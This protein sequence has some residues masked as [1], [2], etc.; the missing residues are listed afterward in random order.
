MGSTIYPITGNAYRGVDTQPTIPGGTIASS[1]SLPGY[2]NCFT[3][4]YFLAQGIANFSILI[5]K[6]NKDTHHLTTLN[7][8]GLLMA[9]CD[10]EIDPAN[11]T[12]GDIR[13]GFGA[14]YD[15][16]SNNVILYHQEGN[17]IT[18]SNITMPRVPE[19]GTVKKNT[20]TML[21][22][23]N[24]V[25]L[26]EIRGETGV[27]TLIHTYTNVSNRKLYPVMI[28]HSS[29]YYALTFM[30]KTTFSP[31]EVVS[32]PS[33][34]SDY[35]ARDIQLTNNLPTNMVNYFNYD[36]TKLVAPT[37][38]AGY[39][40]SA[41]RMFV[42][43]LIERNFIL[44]LITFNVESYDSSQKQRRNIISNIISADENDIVSNEPNIIFIDLNNKNKID[45]RNL[46]MRL[47]DEY[48]NPIN[49]SG[50][51][52]AVLLIAGKEERNF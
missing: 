24:K 4:K 5:R 31:Y 46:T 12:A 50:T 9:L 32:T 18:N 20:L 36:T 37:T 23:G 2:T 26:F 29:I 45:M 3:G 49:I 48:Y 15:S 13:F 43:S 10:K 30:P 51:A 35:P 44:E 52:T 22:S 28:Y 21:V 41:P 11:M 19:N 7:E 47:V 39:D 16:S 33:P 42:P 17:V 1:Q 25:E 14:S 38:I 40:Y 8:Q 6:L 34:I 27:A